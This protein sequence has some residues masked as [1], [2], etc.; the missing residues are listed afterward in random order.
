MARL[1]LKLPHVAWPQSLSVAPPLSPRARMMAIVGG[2]SLLAGLNL[3][4]FSDVAALLREYRHLLNEDLDV[5]GA[6]SDVAFLVA[7]PLG[8]FFAHLLGPRRTLLAAGVLMVAACFGMGFVF[9]A[10]GYALLCLVLGLAAGLVPG[11]AVTAIG[12]WFAPQEQAWA[13]AGVQ[14]APVF[15]ALVASFMMANRT[16]QWGG[17]RLSDYWQGVYLCIALLAAFWLAVT[18]MFYRPRP[19]LHGSDPDQ[20]LNDLPVG[21]LWPLG[22]ILRGGVLAALAFCQTYAL[23]LGGAWLDARLFE[24]WHLATAEVPFVVISGLAGKCAGLLLGGYLSDLA[25]HHS[26]NVK[27]ARQVVIGLGFILGSLA[28]LPLLHLHDLVASG[29]WRGASFFFIGM[30]VPPLWSIALTIAPARSGPV[31][32]MLGLGTSLGLYASPTLLAGLFGQRGW[33]ISFWSG[34]SLCL[35]CGIGA[36]ALDPSAEIEK[37]LPKPAEDGEADGH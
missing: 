30:T 4:L 8:G 18:W 19:G 17:H 21:A 32:G 3:T 28:L 22:V 34:V 15:G 16:W 9:D 12:F 5:A 23:G 35:V 29:I 2:L 6:A 1:S 10:R 37:P 36:F 25:F 7:L 11:A 31:L 27:S 33:D 26:G 14:A 13:I 20:V 24:R